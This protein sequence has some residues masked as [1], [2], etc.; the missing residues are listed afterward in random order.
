MILL[1]KMGSFVS[2]QPAYMFQTPSGYVFRFKIP[3][4]L[5]GLVGKSG[6]RYASKKLFRNSEHT[7][8]LSGRW[9]YQSFTYIQQLFEHII[10]AFGAFFYALAHKLNADAHRRRHWL[11]L[12]AGY[13]GVKSLDELFPHISL[14]DGN[15]QAGQLIIGQKTEIRF[16][17]SSGKVTSTL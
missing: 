5:R 12:R 4:D 7:S 6:F 3:K 17:F 15:F 14:S 11:G 16:T 9:G 1:T 13:W 10:Y 2:R 8:Y